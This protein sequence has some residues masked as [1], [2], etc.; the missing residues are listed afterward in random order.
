MK[1]ETPTCNQLD[2]Q[3]LRVSTS[4]A[5]QSPRALGSKPNPASDKRKSSKIAKKSRQILLVEIGGR[6]SA[7]PPS[8]VEFMPQPGTWPACLS[9]G[10]H[11]VDLISLPVGCLCIPTFFP[12]LFFYERSPSRRRGLITSCV[13]KTWSHPFPRPR[14]CIQLLLL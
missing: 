6:G 8:P 10:F 7:C 4:Y 14:S 13:D 2:L 11:R 5:Q 12:S 3:T 1:S 9:R